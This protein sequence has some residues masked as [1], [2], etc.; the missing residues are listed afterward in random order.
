MCYVIR[1]LTVTFFLDNGG[2]YLDTDIIVLRSFDPLR[3]FATTLGRETSYGLGSG[4]ILAEPNS[5]FIHLWLNSFKSYN[6]WPWNWAKYAVWT[7]HVL[8]RQ[9]AEEIHIEETRLQHPTW[10]QSDQLCEKLYDWS[11]NYAVHVWKR[12]CE[13]PQ[14]VEEINSLNNTLGE[15]FRYVYYG[16]KK[17][18]QTSESS[19]PKSHLKRSMSNYVDVMGH[20]FLEY[21]NFNN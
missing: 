17:L 12:F 15:V 14:T 9:F 2:I 1:L 10:A 3:R 5:V 8:A 7:P 21:I 4:I 6:P 19:K 13:V 20:K 16:S 18:R 11:E